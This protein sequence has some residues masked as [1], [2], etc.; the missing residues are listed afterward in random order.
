MLGVC[1]KSH[2]RASVCC[3][4]VT[5][6][7]LPLSPDSEHWLPE[8]LAAL[9]NPH[10]LERCSSTLSLG[11]VRLD[12]TDWWLWHC[13]R[14][15]S[16]HDIANQ[17]PPLQQDDRKACWEWPP[18]K[19]P[20]HSGWKSPSWEMQYKAGWNAEVLGRVPQTA[21][22][23]LEKL[24]WSPPNCSSYLLPTYVSDKVSSSSSLRQPPL[25]GCLH[26]WVCAS[27][28]WLR[29]WVAPCCLAYWTRRSENLG[30]QTCWRPCRCE[31][32][33]CPWDGV[34]WSAEGAAGIRPRWWWW[35][36]G[37]RWSP[38]PRSWWRSSSVCWTSAWRWWPASALQRWTGHSCA[39]CQPA[40][41]EKRGRM[42]SLLSTVGQKKMDSA[43]E[44]GGGC[45]T[46]F[47]EEIRFSFFLSPPTLL[48][49]TS[50]SKYNVSPI[51]CL[52]VFSDT[53]T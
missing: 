52:L 40:D 46:S 32:W 29:P 42:I 14:P 1:A 3:I 22:H 16:H 9:C 4:V 37:R 48:R 18:F 44:R 12:T 23:L 51:N 27:L 15:S 17:S 2:G 49:F 28:G 24:G 41:K 36:S 53:S 5:P 7:L 43:P 8:D 39:E 34:Q 13:C 45:L 35:T 30:Q 38:P 31:L 10:T 25:R 50:R 21:L 20:N 33:S 19:A 11:T 6:K 47:I 26:R